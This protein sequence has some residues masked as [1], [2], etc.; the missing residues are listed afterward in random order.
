MPYC[1]L[2]LLLKSEVD[3]T[4]R[5]GEQQPQSYRVLAKRKYKTLVSNY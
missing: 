2:Y 1:P 4:N 5:V 3:Q